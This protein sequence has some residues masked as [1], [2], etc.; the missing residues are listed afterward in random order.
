MSARKLMIRAIL[1]L[2]IFLLASTNVFAAYSYSP[3]SN[4]S[5]TSKAYSPYYISGIFGYDD[6]H[7]ELMAK[8]YNMKWNQTKKNNLLSYKNNGQYYTIDIAVN[9]DND[10]TMSAWESTYYT[11]LPGP[12]FDVEDDPWPFGNDY[13]DEAEVTMTRPDLLYVD[14][15]YEFITHWT[16]YKTSGT[17]FEWNSQL[18]E[19]S[20]T[21]EYNTVDYEFHFSKT[22]PWW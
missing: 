3:A 14:Q 7:R 2:S 5:S 11:N 20:L 17:T 9:N 6:V 16:V 22:F 21:G 8:A 4:D 13:N 1:P 19:R 12:V 10:V 18:S 15:A